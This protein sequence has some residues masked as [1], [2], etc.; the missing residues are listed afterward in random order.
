M[1]RHALFVG[2]DE[3]ADP[4]IQKLN[5]PSEDAAELAS[6][7]RLL[8]K[9]DRAEK[10]VNPD[11]ADDILDAVRD[12]ARGLGQGDLFLFFF[13]GHGFRVKDNH[14]LVCGK[15]GYEDLKDEDAGLRVGRLKRRMAGPWSRM[16]VLDACQNDI[17]A[18]R[19]VDV[20][21]TARDLELIH[22]SPPGGG[23]SG[24]QIVVTSCSEGQRALEVSDLGHGLF[25]SALL[26]SVNALADARRRI[27]LETLR[28]DL[29]DRM[30]RLIDR[31]RLSG[32]QMPLFTMPPSAADI[33][34]FDGASPVPNAIAPVRP[35]AP[36][37]TLV[38]CPICGKKNEPKDTFRCK[39]CG[40]DNL[41][42]RH[43]DTATFLCPD[44]EAKARKEAERNRPGAVLPVTVAGVSFNLRRIP[45]KG[46]QAAFWMGET[47]VTQKLWKAVMGSNPSRFGS[48]S[49]ENAKMLERLGVEAKDVLK[50]ESF[51]AHPVECVSWENIC[52]SFLK[53]L[54]ER[55]DVL[56]TG[57]V[58]RLPTEEE[59]EHACRAGGSGRYCRLADGTEITAKTLDRVA[60]YQDHSGGTT[61]PAGRK[62]PNAWGLFDMLG[63]VCEW[64]QTAD[65]G[66]RILRGGSWDSPAENCEASH[67]W[68]RKP[69]DRG[70]G[71]LGFRLCASVRDD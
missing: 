2:V 39:E 46:T 71:G 54:N 24:C 67:Q 63:N 32:E 49:R 29:G 57:L 14:V 3:Y 30:G 69:D 58:F 60:W 47:P 52:Q 33:V 43:Q 26:D 7:F 12:M 28:A 34:L 11:H 1:K 36:A 65:G 27:D 61:H 6:A 4:T 42:L 44:C 70:K 37:P 41:C 48:W 5:Y 55:D 13:A 59:W 56:R 10:L 19:G 22:A 8:L 40:R 16:L 51:E 20:G 38:V 35:V 18:T 68:K 25:T 31:Y 17:R 45:A 64:T 21:A 50:V 62:E 66:K 9:F 53:K 23:G 15:D